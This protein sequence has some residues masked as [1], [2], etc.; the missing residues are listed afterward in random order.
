MKPH[1]PSTEHEYVKDT[2]LLNVMPNSLVDVS[3]VMEERAAS[4]F[5]VEGQA[6]SERACK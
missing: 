2:W 4:I 5:R 1:K 3:Y 6:Y